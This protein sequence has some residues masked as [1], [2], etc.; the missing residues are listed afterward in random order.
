MSLLG[1]VFY[2]DLVRQTR[3]AL[4]TV[5]RLLYLGTLFLI[6]LFAHLNQSSFSRDGQLPPGAVSRMVQE[7]C[8][9]FLVMQFLL[10]VALTPAL[11]AGSLTEEKEKQT[12]PFLLASSLRNHEIVLGKLASRL[13]SVLL[14]VIAGLPVF[15]LLQLLGGIDPGWLLAGFIASGAT[16]LSLAAVSIAWSALLSRSRDALLFA[17]LSLPAYLLLARASLL[18]LS[19]NNLPALDALV[20]AFSAGD[21]FR[22]YERSL[23]S[24][25][26]RG[27]D[28]LDEVLG[29]YLLFH[30]IVTFCCLAIAVLQVRR[31]ALK[32]ASIPQGP[33]SIR[34]TR[35][36][37]DRPILWREL[38]AERGPRLHWLARVVLVILVGLSFLPAMFFL[39]GEPKS[40]GLERDM[41]IWVRTVGTLVACLLLLAVGIRAAGSISGER[42]KQTFDILLTTPLELREIL[43]GKWLGAVGSI[44]KG[45]VW[46]VAIAGLG[47]GTGG[48]HIVALPLLGI[49]WF[50]QASFMATLGL[51]FSLR[52]RSTLQATG[53][54]ISATLL[55]WLGPFFVLVCCA[56]GGMGLRSL[57]M[58]LAA[59]VPPATL[60]ILAFSEM[61]LSDMHKGGREWIIYVIIGQAIWAI[62]AG[63]LWARTVERFL[64]M[65]G[66]TEQPASIRVK[67]TE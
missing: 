24:L 62:C 33:S 23:D 9:I 22:A 64:T 53:A 29:E 15:S 44:R 4:P 7:F 55:L 46:L 27:A 28:S 51:Y 60:G 61:E 34:E 50:I 67:Q 66:R 36:V 5:V 41:N 49:C 38:H 48:L 18:L 32:E 2:F 57:E 65:T 3:R 35:Q 31:V 63:V 21:P 42:Q 56:N 40:S 20:L 19:N 37:D 11:T 25:Y 45:W 17:Y 54:T 12:M 1:P 10:I 26:G 59:L 30:G 14:I 39:H 58:F 47:I 52:C 13:V 8:S 43:S 6:L 16:L